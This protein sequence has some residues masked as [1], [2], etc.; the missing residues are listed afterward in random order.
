MM[1]SMEAVRFY[2]VVNSDLGLTIGKICTHVAYAVSS[3]YL[4]VISEQKH[5]LEGEMEE[6]ARVKT[7]TDQGVASRAIEWL[8]QGSQT[9][10]LRATEKEIDRLP[11]PRFVTYTETDEAAV[12]GWL[13]SPSEVPELGKL[14]SIY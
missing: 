8:L 10:I 13:A 5:H 14:R 11:S 6:E 2:I 3:L 4:E 12:L 1:E 7:P 9:A